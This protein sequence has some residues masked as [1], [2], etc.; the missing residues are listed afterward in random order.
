VTES[1]GLYLPHDPQGRGGISPICTYPTPPVGCGSWVVGCGGR[2]GRGGKTSIR[3]KSLSKCQKYHIFQKN[4][5]VTK[6]T[7]FISTNLVLKICSIYFLYNRGI[8]PCMDSF[9]IFLI[10]WFYHFEQWFHNLRK[11]PTEGKLN[12]TMNI[13]NIMLATLVWQT[14]VAF[15]VERIKPICL[16]FL[17]I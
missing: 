8:N 5:S 16:F 11:W 13:S 4:C 6:A 12:T 17:N 2:G 3:V 14:K 1:W 7:C 9:K 10:S 15:R